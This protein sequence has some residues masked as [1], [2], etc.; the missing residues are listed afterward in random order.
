MQS[1][2]FRHV[3]VMVFPV[4]VMLSSSSSSYLIFLLVSSFTTDLLFYRLLPLLKSYFSISEMI[5]LIK[6]FLF[7]LYSLF[8]PPSSMIVVSVVVI[9]S[10]FL[11]IL[12]LFVY[13]LNHSVLWTLSLI[14]AGA[15]VEIASLSAILGQNFILWFVHWLIE[16]NDTLSFRRVLMLVYWF[17]LLF[18]SIHLVNQGILKSEKQI[19]QRKYFHFLAVGLFLPCSLIDPSF[20]QY[21]FSLLLIRVAFAFAYLVLLLLEIFRITSLLPLNDFMLSFTDARDNGP[22]ILTHFSLLIGCALPIWVLSDSKASLSTV[23]RLAGIVSIGI[24]DSF[25]SSELEHYV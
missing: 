9:E 22:F 25:V 11:T 21:P 18:V 24:G 20:M 17:S 2:V 5:L 8:L 6:F 4:Y 1:S 3:S 13:S 10:T 15:A 16:S 7:F 19:I 14:V 23:G 12:V